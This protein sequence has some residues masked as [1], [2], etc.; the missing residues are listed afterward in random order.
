ML[1][2]RTWIA[3]VL[4]AISFGGETGSSSH[5][6]PIELVSPLNPASY[7]VKSIALKRDL[8]FSW[9]ARDV[10]QPSARHAFDPVRLLTRADDHDTDVP[11]S[12]TP[13][14][15]SPEAL[16]RQRRLARD[17]LKKKKPK[18][19]DAYR[20]ADPE[21]TKGAPAPPNVATDEAK[22]QRRLSRQALMK[23][24]KS[25]SK[26]TAPSAPGSVPPAAGDNLQASTNPAVKPITRRKTRITCRIQAVG[27][28]GD[29]VERCFKNTMFKPNSV[30]QLEAAG[31]VPPGERESLLNR[32]GRLLFRKEEKKGSKSKES[33]H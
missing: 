30:T 33:A 26:E 31:A 13:S 15:L 7:P 24:S 17:Q 6:L 14:S 12:P 19:G 29:I 1:S 25:T 23:K 11:L 27:D 10:L 28:S 20:Q 18:P 2:T 21:S 5:A 4:L 8:D 22:K 16:R 32:K 3:L 9:T